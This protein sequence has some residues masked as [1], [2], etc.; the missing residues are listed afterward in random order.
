MNNAIKQHELQGCNTV[1]PLMMPAVVICH[2][3][4]AAAGNVGWFIVEP[5][6]IARFSASL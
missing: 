6:L 5:K 1:K 2:C 4:D 3:A